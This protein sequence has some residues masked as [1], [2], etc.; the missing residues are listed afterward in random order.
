MSSAESSA[1][2]QA[3]SACQSQVV[4]RSTCLPLG[5]WMRAPPKLKEDSRSSLIVG[6][7]SLTG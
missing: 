4:K 5:S 1:L 6:C 3:Q 7:F 2:P